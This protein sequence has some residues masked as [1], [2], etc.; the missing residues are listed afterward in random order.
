MWQ[1]WKHAFLAIANKHAPLRMKRVRARSSRWIT[2][3]IKDLMHK[4]DILKIKAIKSNA[5]NDWMLY[6]RQR[7]IANKEI[8]L[9]KQAYYQNSFNEHTGDSRKTWQTI[10]ELTSR[11]SGK[12]SVTSLKINELAITDTREISNQF[13]INHFSTISPQLASEIDSDS[14]D[15]LR[16]LPPTDKPFQLHPT[17]PSKVFSLM[18]KLNKSKTTGLDRISA[19]LI[20]E[21]ADLICVPIRLEV[22]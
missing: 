3:R 16:Y 9:T 7:N 8:R 21:C 19:R 18:N 20:R 14:G 22:G 2:S 5:L 6:K 13:N 1:E 11:E 17:D 4:R 12:T 15:Y 10:N